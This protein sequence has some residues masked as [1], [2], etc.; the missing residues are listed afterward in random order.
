MEFYFE[1]LYG[2]LTRVGHFSE[3]DFG[4]RITQPE[5]P[6]EQFK[7]YSLNDADI[8]VIGDSFSISRIWQTK[9]IADGLKVCTLSWKEL[10]ADDSIPSDLGDMLRMAGFKGHRVILESVERIFQ[11]RM[12]SLTKAHYPIVKQEII[13]N[14]SFQMYP[15]TQRKRISLDKPN[16][17]DWGT[18]AL[19][20]KIKL[21]LS[22]PEKYL[23]FGWVQPVKFDGCQLFSHRL[24][25]YMLFIE[26]DFKKETFSSI[27]NVLTVNKN[28]QALDIQPIW[29]VIPDKSTVY[30]GYGKFNR[31]PY[32]N[33]WQ[34]FAQY[35]ELIAPDLGEVFTQ[36]SRM[37]KDFYMPNDT[38]LSTNGFLYLGDFMTK[39]LHKLQANQPNPF[40]Q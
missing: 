5:I 15:F 33:I 8:V 9:L 32:Q 24:C 27:T 40:A 25:S 14:T 38:H 11:R 37:I 35:P 20:N 6:I 19:Y 34:Q 36:Q 7:N 23:K 17:G 22:L 29:L 30:L 1:K 18:K 21:S 31:N 13:I 12:A 2:D 28:L 39:G 16:G 4:W 10:K 26:S 3:R